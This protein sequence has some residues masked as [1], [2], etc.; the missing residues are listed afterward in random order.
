MRIK[1]M[2]SVLATAV[3][4]ALMGCNGVVDLGLGGDDNDA[5]NSDSSGEGVEISVELGT[6]DQEG[7]GLQTYKAENFATRIKNINFAIRARCA[8]DH[9]QDTDSMSWAWKTSG[10]ANDTAG[11]GYDHVAHNKFT[12]TLD[13]GCVDPQT[14]LNGLVFNYADADDDETPIVQSYATEGDF[15]TAGQAGIYYVDESD[16]DQAHTWNGGTESYDDATIPTVDTNNLEW[17]AIGAA[18][19]T[20]D[21]QDSVEAA[22]GTPIAGFPDVDTWGSD[23]NTDM[24][25]AIP[26]VNVDSDGTESGFNSTLILFHNATKA[27]LPGEDPIYTLAERVIRVDDDVNYEVEIS[28]LDVTVEVLT[29][30]NSWCSDI[31]VDLTT[32]GKDALVVVFHDPESGARPNGSTTYTI[33]TAATAG[34]TGYPTTNTSTV[35]QTASTPNAGDASIELDFQTLDAA[36][37]NQ[38]YGITATLDPNG[39]GA[40]AAENAELCEAQIEYRLVAADADLDIQ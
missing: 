9:S 4:F 25:A 5:K 30:P 16:S 15:P 19:G 35:V 39:T 7:F 36:D 6:G 18:S 31:T 20:D 22:G 24:S 14:L 8:A 21:T 26:A 37:I 2:K 27:R 28:P 3:G 32:S 10:Y 29:Q 40:T 38:D 13:A 33:T 11:V 17:Q 23:D 34:F 12:Y 1:F